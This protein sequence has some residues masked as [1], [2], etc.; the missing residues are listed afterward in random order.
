MTRIY[1]LAFDTKDALKDYQAMME[2]AKKRDH[3]LG[4]WL[5]MRRWV[6]A[7][8]GLYGPLRRTA[9]SVRKL[10]RI[11]RAAPS[12]RASAGFELPQGL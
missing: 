8:A 6:G 5:A 10:W 7:L 2:E 4:L 3:R 1:G 9:I 12:N 11:C